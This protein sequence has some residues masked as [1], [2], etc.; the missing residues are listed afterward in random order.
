MEHTLRTRILARYDQLTDNFKKL[1]DFLLNSPTEVPLL[2]SAALGNRVGVSNATVVRFAQML[3]YEGY[4][5]LKS[6]LLRDLREELKPE[7]RFKLAS[8]RGQEDTLIRVAKQDVYNIN[9]TIARIHSEE[10]REIVDCIAR[11]RKV[12]ILGVGLSASLARLASYL[13]QQVGVEA[14]SS[15]AEVT[16]IEEKI[17][18][19]KRQDL[20]IGFSF[21]PYSVTT[22][23]FAELARREN[24]PLMTITDKATS[25]MALIAEYKLFI[26]NENI[27]FTN[28]F[29]AFAVVINAIA[30]EIGLRNHKQ[31]V[32]ENERIVQTLEQFYET[33]QYKG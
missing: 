17:L 12:L 32:R 8:K 22:L 13:L 5:D 18:R 28:S 19:L 3:G 30:T 21:P 15:D 24:I 26:T 1:A 14:I 27:L 20:V 9:H 23:Q 2:S 10:F 7:E 4:P 33:S 16:P 29:A 31:L 6:D 25:P 11:S